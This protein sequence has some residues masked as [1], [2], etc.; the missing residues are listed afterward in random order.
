MK[1]LTDQQLRRLFDATAADVDVGLPPDVLRN[2]SHAGAA[3]LERRR[4]LLLV[5]ASIVTAVGVTGGTYWLTTTAND[6]R[7]DTFVADPSDSASPPSP[8]SSPGNDDRAATCEGE[9]VNVDFGN[10]Y[11]SP[12]KALDALAIA[13]GQ[14]TRLEQAP[15]S[16]APVDSVARGT[17]L[18]ARG[19]VVKSVSM[20]LREDGWTVARITVC[21]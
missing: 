18:D 21:N 8:T 17:V 4:T 1:H 12:E 15:P 13:P 11:S 19:T 10:A 5:A 2:R 16:D 20:S 14:S 7:P 9:V 6:P 3:Q